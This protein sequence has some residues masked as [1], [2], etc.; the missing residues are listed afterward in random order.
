ML[1]E[2][3]QV[4]T[5]PRVCQGQAGAQPEGHVQNG[6]KK[7]RTQ[8]KR[9]IWDLRPRNKIWRQVIEGLEC[10]AQGSGLYSQRDG[11]HPSFCLGRGVIKAVPRGD[12]AP[13]VEL[14]LTPHE[15]KTTTL[16]QGLGLPTHEENSTSPS[17]INVGVGGKLREIK[18]VPTC[19]GT[20]SGTAPG[21]YF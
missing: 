12:R 15:T 14:Q 2:F 11:S 3:Q 4:G 21:P 17:R 5:G 9:P 20:R 7:Q 13:T 6:P 1:V 8:D 16:P 19:T 10:Q 18:L